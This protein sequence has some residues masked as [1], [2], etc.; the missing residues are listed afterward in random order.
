LEEHK[1]KKSL[2]G[3]LFKRGHAHE[4]Y[5][6]SS[7]YTGDLEEL[8]RHYEHPHSD[9][10][11][12]ATIYHSE[13]YDKTPT[14][15]ETTPILKGLIV[16]FS[17]LLPISDYP[18]YEEFS[19]PIHSIQH[20]EIRTSPIENLPHQAYYDKLEEHKPKKSLF[21]SL[22]KRTHAHMDFPTSPAYTGDL[23]DLNRHFEHPHS[24]IGQHSTP[25]STGFYNKLEEKP[26]VAF[27]STEPYIGP[28]SSTHY[29]EIQQTP[30][31]HV[32]HQGYYNKLE[33]KPTHTVL[34]VSKEP[35]P[36][37]LSKEP[38]SGPLHSIQHNEI[39]SSPIENIYNAGFYNKLE[40]HKPKTSLF[41]SLFKR[42]H[43]DEYPISE[44]YSGE[45]QHTYRNFE[46][47]HSDIG[48]HAM[49]YHSGVYDKIEERPTVI[50]T[51]PAFKGIFYC[52]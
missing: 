6:T 45:Y 30:I 5:P 14:V 25:Y 48:Q 17:K 4:N 22:F 49:P 35:S 9:I 29:Q 26:G 34:K 36:Y 11:Q 7:V 16:N 51:T 20:S 32:Y 10:G 33:E 38:Y 44:V 15:I 1:P 43:R 18:A 37:D 8:H 3:S 46:H 24:D 52:I 21:G 42:E 23:E 41:G 39:E 2:F 12:H 19:G 31:R 13:V 47:P 50:E 28:L 40:E 27:V